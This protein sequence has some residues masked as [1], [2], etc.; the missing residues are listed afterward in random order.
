VAK[1]TFG[2]TQ[3]AA[4]RLEEIA[5]VFNPLASPFVAAY[6]PKNADTAVDLGCGPGLTTDMLARATG[7]ARVYGLDKS[8]DFLAMA[9]A[10]FPHCTFV[11][12]DITTVPFPVT[13]DVLYARFILSH[14]PGPTRVVDRWATQL[15]DTGVLLVE[16]VE[17]I[18]T[19]VEV[20]QTYLS[21]NETMIAAQGACLFVGRELAEGTYD[22]HVVHNECLVLPVPNR[23]AATWFL[24]NTLTVWRENEVVLEH[25]GPSAIEAI[26]Q[27]LLQI[28]EGVHSGGDAMWKMRRLVLRRERDHE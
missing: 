1:Y 10:R 5:K 15:A 21:M 12:H 11:E 7:C 17:A 3:E 8:T 13:G 2:T 22:A 6:A 9:R 19:D 23:Q 14:L 4:V 20:F 18:D 28:K 16:E 26:S 24:P 25:L 27:G